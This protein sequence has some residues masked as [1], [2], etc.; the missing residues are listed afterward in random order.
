MLLR[1]KAAVIATNIGPYQLRDTIGRGGFATVKL[2]FHPDQA[3]PYACKIVP[4]TKLPSPRAM[5]AFE[6]EIGIL[7]QLRHP[8]IVRLYDFLR[9]SDNFYVFLEYCPGGDLHTKMLKGRAL[10]EEEARDYFRQILVGVD[11]CHELGIAHRD[12]KPENV[13]IDGDGRLKLSDFGLSRFCRENE[14]AT[15]QCGSPLFTAP[16]IL[17]GKSYIPKPTDMWSLGLI[18]YQMV[19]GKLPWKSHNKILLWRQITAGD[20]GFPEH[21]S[22]ECLNLLKKLIK[23]QPAERVTCKEALTDEWVQSANLSIPNTVRVPFVSLRKIDS[24]FTPEEPIDGE[25][26]GLVN[27]LST[28]AIQTTFARE[29]KMIAASPERT[30]M[31]WRGHIPVRGRPRLI[32]SATPDILRAASGLQP[33]PPTVTRLSKVPPPRLLTFTE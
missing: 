17:G 18:L 20:I 27:N 28:G 1:A 7:R 26:I 21:L 6:R 33:R 19:C 32:S 4:L 23:T 2:A 10:P 16:E 12:L 22:P 5:A 11:H 24:M 15:T 25:E 30:P 3:E 8:A 31:Q 13:L 9:D 29:V 14:L